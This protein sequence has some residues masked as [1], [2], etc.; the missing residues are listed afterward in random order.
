V[1]H[2]ALALWATLAVSPGPQASV[3]RVAAAHYQRG[4]A[5][6]KETNYAAA[7]AEFKAAHEAVPHWEVLLNIGLCERRLFRYGHALQALEQYLKE[8]AGRVP[9]GRRS[10]VA[11]EIEQIRGLTASVELRVDGPEARL[12][13]DQ[14]LY[15]TSPLSAPVALASGRHLLRAER[16]GCRPDER[17]VDVVSGQPQTVTLA[18]RSLT[19]PVRISVQ[20]EPAAAL[21]RVDGTEPVAAPADLPLVP[22]A[23]RLAVTA[24][25]FAPSQTELLVEPA[26]PRTLRVVLVPIALPPPVAAAAPERPFPVAGVSL[27]ATG[28]VLAGV[29]LYF[30]LE[31]R[32]LGERV[33]GLST[34]GG[35]WTDS[36]AGVDAAGRRDS[37]LGW[38][39]LAAGGA[40]LVTGAVVT[41][42]SVARPS[43]TVTVLPLTG[44][45]L[46]S[47]SVRF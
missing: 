40:A 36:W 21:L 17:S 10:A 44:G 18:P 14:E 33:T 13:I 32:A 34:S 28:L 20:T 3:R 42:V 1:P 23:H 26:E 38:G 15:G 37:L 41:G 45:A 4:V 31:A 35:T 46:A 24:E 22:G 8:G 11:Q 19:E 47:C 5:L 12:Y 39:F 6:F 16:D 30:A 9:A 27:V 43:T 25:G 7:L 29:G 2:L